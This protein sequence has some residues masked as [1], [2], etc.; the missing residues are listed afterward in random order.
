MFEYFLFQIDSVAH[1]NVLYFNWLPNYLH[2]YVKLCTVE[3][4]SFSN[5]L[6]TQSS[7]YFWGNGQFVTYNGIGK[8]FMN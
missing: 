1:H 7:Q 4:E 8:L 3:K 6:L 2:L 5:L